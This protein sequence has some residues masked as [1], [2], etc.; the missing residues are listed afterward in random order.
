M[1]QKA[2]RLRG[3]RVSIVGA[4]ALIWYKGNFK[5]V[6]GALAYVGVVM[7]GLAYLD[8]A[9]GCTLRTATACAKVSGLQIMA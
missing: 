9:P 5:P 6:A 1:T 8:E 4:L 7:G 2:K 3:Q